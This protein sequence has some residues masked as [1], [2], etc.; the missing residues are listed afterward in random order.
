M[1]ISQSIIRAEHPH[2]ACFYILFTAQGFLQWGRG[3]T[4]GIHPHNGNSDL[5]TCQCEPLKIFDF[6]CIFL[7][8]C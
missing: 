6:D 1:L 7:K 2:L 3:G 5:L 4:R 8:F